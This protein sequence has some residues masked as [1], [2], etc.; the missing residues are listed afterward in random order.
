MHIFFRD[1]CNKK[2]LNVKFFL[3]SNILVTIPLNL[4]GLKGGCPSNL[5]EAPVGIHGLSSIA[6][7]QHQTDLV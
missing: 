7:C 1:V 4:P 2:I 3:K 5:Q 6:L